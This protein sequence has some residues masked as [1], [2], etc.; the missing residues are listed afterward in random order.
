MGASVILAVAT[1]A[2]TV[3][4]AAAPGKWQKIANKPAF[5][6]DTALL[7]TDG[8]LMV[9]H[10][11]SFFHGAILNVNYNNVFNSKHWEEEKTGQLVL[12]LI[13]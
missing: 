12:V 10:F 11:D 2:Q 4:G 3:Q 13:I 5:N 1:M 8:R 6:T 9:H 7:L